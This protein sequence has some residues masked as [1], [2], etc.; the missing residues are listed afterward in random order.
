MRSKE[1][2]V[3][4]YCASSSE[5]DRVYVEAATHLG[6]LLVKASPVSTGRGTGTDRCLE[7]LGDPSRRESS[8][9]IPLYGG[10]RMVP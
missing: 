3:V 9:V 10:C 1:L 2:S 4:V 6:L 7:Q 8:G 5:I